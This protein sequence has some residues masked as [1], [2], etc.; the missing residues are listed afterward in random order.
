[1]VKRKG[2][3]RSV[4]R[5]RQ[6]F[7]VHYEDEE[8]KLAPHTMVFHR[9][10]CNKALRHLV[11][12]MRQVM[13]PYT[14]TSLKNTKKNCLK[15]FIT[16]A[17]PLH[18]SHLM[19]FSETEHD[20]YIKMIRLPRGPTLHYKIEEFSLNKDVISGIKKPATNLKQF[21]H[22]PLLVLNGF[23]LNEES[24]PKMHHKLMATM[25][26]NMFPSINVSKIHLNEIRR[27]AMFNFN[28]EDETLDF[29]H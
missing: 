21:L 7:G 26:Q 20:G 3:G 27:C 23:N 29:R 10:E 12:D 8:V 18:V 14:A 28:A 19:I 11:K 24:K 13:E 9:G 4:K 2:K 22:Q 25:F 1:M 17:G 5:A 15:D 6:K 16:I